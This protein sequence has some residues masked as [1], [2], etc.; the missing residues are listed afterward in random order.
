MNPTEPFQTFVK[1]KKT[2]IVLETFLAV[3]II[4]IGVNQKV[5]ET[6]QTDFMTQPMGG[7]PVY[8]GKFPIPAHSHMYITEELFNLRSQLLRDSLKEANVPDDLAKR[9]LEIDNAFK[10]G[11]VKKSIADCTPRYKGDEF[12]VFPD[13]SKTPA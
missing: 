13:P 1:Q 9:W 5:Q 3:L 10:N 8:C 4:F 7:E 11:I 6:Q 2:L 12:L